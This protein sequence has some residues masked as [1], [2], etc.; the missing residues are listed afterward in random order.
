MY[1]MSS[2]LLVMEC[3]V[4]G[5]FQAFPYQ[6]VS[7]LFNLFHNVFINTYD[8]YAAI[9]FYYLLFTGINHGTLLTINIQ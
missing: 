1:L 2:V 6:M 7:I 9:T 3:R 8:I 4:S 5:M